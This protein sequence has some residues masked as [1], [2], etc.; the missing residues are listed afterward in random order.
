MLGIVKNKNDNRLLTHVFAQVQGEHT[1]VYTYYIHAYVF[2][3]TVPTKIYLII[4]WNDL[5]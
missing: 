2:I 1:Y 4:I 3:H 5:I